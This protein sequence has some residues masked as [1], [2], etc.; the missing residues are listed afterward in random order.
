MM[1]IPFFNLKRIN[2]RYA[3]DMEQAV[4]RVSRSGWYI[5]GIEKECFEKEF[6][7]YCGTDYCIGVGNGLDALRLIF[8]AYKELGIMEDGDEVIIP[9]N[10]FIATALAVSQS[11]LTPIFADCDGDTYN[12]AVNSIEEKITHRTKAIVAVHLYGQIAPMEELRVIAKKYNLKLIEDAAQA[13]GAVYRGRKAGNLSDAAAFSFYPVK[14][15]G[16][17]GDAGAVATNDE[18]LACL[19][20]SFSNYGSNEKYAHQYKGLNSRLDEMQAAVLSVKLK[21]LDRD[22]EERKCIAS[23]YSANIKND[24]IILPHVNTIEAHVFHQYVIR[25][26]KRDELQTYLQD[27]GIQTQIHYPKAIHKQ[28]AYK[29]FSS[30]CFPV[31]E[32]LQD[33]ILS[34]PVYPT[35][36]KEEM[37]EVVMVLNNWL[38]S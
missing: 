2:E 28:E 33:E 10:T 25:C 14:N 18:S 6:A 34:L 30:L 19:V 27:N 22:N 9:V 31:A 29:E 13:H 16:A 38:R 23:Y 37:Q 1:Q 12:I 11:S 15:I 35:M 7:D 21:Y 26:K 17:L 24:G 5:S 4:L 36:T 20:R 8:M 3:S 32:K